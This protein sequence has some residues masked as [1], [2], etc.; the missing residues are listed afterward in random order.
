MINYLTNSLL[1][2]K[3]TSTIAFAIIT[4]V[5]HLHEGDNVL[6]LTLDEPLEIIGVGVGG[7][8]LLLLLAGKSF[9]I[10]DIC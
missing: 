8:C 3:L 2:N 4:D 7:F 6:D 5:K 9:T 10:K 1:L